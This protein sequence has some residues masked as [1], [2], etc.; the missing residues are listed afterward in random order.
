MPDHLFEILAL[1]IGSSGVI[2]WFRL[3]SDRALARATRRRTDAETENIISTAARRAVAISQA[4]MGELEKELA[5]AES[6]IEAL[7]AEVTEQKRRRYDLA[8]ALELE[9]EQR[10]KLADRVEALEAWIKLNTSIDP[11]T[12]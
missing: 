1:L 3:G 5:H 4:A 7:E 12:I 11:E 6:R 2:A 8:A 9:K 10:S